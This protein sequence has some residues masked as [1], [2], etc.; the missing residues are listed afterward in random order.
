M[1]LERLFT[2][3]MNYTTR[4]SGDLSVGAVLYNESD[5]MLNSF[6]WFFPF[7]QGR[8]FERG[9]RKNHSVGKE[10]KAGKHR[11]NVANAIKMI[12]S[13]ATWLGLPACGRGSARPM[14][15]LA[16]WMILRNGRLQGLYIGLFVPFCC[17]RVLMSCKDLNNP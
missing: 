9:K 12:P 17:T 3:K 2:H 6:G 11:G 1:G 14:P 8:F 16:H 4:L 15:F 7:L 5:F 13:L 10:R